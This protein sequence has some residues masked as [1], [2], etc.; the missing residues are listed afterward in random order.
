[1]AVQQRGYPLGALFVLVTT[2]AV[3]LAG[4]TPLVRAAYRGETDAG[5]LVVALLCG[6]AAGAVLGLVIGLQHFHRGLGAML[7]LLAGSVIGGAAGLTALLPES[8]ILTAAAAIVAGSGLIVGVALVM[9]RTS[10]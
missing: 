2:S 4:T 9:R 6:M 10:S 8:R 5:P 3:L 7:G 1:M